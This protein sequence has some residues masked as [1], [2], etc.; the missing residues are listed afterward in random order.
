MWDLS[1]DKE[2]ESSSMMK[3][4]HEMIVQAPAK[5][6]PQISDTQYKNVIEAIRVLEA[7]A[8]TNEIRLR[9][10]TSVEQIGEHLLAAEAA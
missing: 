10:M 7:E 4:N 8:D 5:N 9:P 6:D 2:R 1:V 3:R